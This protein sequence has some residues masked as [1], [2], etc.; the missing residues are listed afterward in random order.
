ME[1]KGE[2]IEVRRLLDAESLDEDGEQ[3]L[4]TLGIALTLFFGSSW[5]RIL[6]LLEDAEISHEELQ[7]ILALGLDADSRSSVEG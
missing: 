7:G 4:R 6:A 5:G 2:P 1:S 3:F